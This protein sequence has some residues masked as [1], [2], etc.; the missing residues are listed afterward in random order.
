MTDRDLYEILGVERTAEASTIKKAYR[1]LALKYHPDKNPGD[2]EAEERFKE[3]AEAYAI[4]SDAEKRARYDRFGMA[5]LGG[6]AGFRGF[7]Q[8][9]F[10]DFSDI[11][12][13]LFGFGF[14]DVFGG[15]RRGRRQRGVGQDLRYELEIEFEDA[16]RGMQTRILV[17]RHESCTHCEGTG[18]E[19]PDGVQ[20]CSQCA[21][22]G[23]VAFQQGFF[24]I[25][26]PCSRCGGKGREIVRPCGTCEGT[27]RIPRERTLELK[28]PP[29]V[30]DGTRLRIAG[31]GEAGAVGAPPGDLYVVLH[32]KEHPVFTRRDDHILCEARISFAQA[33]LGTR[34]EVPTLDGEQDLD[35]PA[36]TQSGTVFRLAGQGIPSLGGRGRGDQFVS[37]VVSTPKKLTQE[38]REIFERLAEIEGEETGERGLFDRVKDIFN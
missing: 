37:V 17:P 34:L 19:P 12:G 2:N 32:V 10:S 8:E 26:R 9:I 25:A 30:G 16:A 21:G 29:G 28:I 35:V 27:G 23:Q 18:G 13:D 24:T 11:L 22:R 38:T 7:D 3:A 20:T 31:E 15:G 36:G 5:G 4:L 33:A 6:Q 14:G 1:R